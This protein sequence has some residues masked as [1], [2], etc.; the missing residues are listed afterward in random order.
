MN[1]GDLKG[2]TPLHYACCPNYETIASGLVD[3]WNKLKEKEKEKYIQQ[4]KEIIIQILK[5]FIENSQDINQISSDHR[6]AFSLAVSYQNYEVAE[7]LLENPNFDVFRVSQADTCVYHDLA[8]VL[9]DKEGRNLFNKVVD[10]MGHRNHEFVNQIDI[11]GFTP[12]LQ[13]IKLYT[14]SSIK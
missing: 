1:I 11:F 14:Q 9:V 3:D 13:S 8:A 5:L 2:W 4:S 10:L 12:F 7:L 6:S